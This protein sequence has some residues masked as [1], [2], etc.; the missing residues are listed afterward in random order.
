MDRVLQAVRS[1][2]WLTRE[3]IR[4]VAV[5][6]LIA[7]AAGFL[8]LVV[9]A[10]GG[11]DR[12]GRPIGTDFS[13]VYAAGTYVLEGNPVAPF[14]SVQQFARER[15]IFGEATQ[16]Y[17][18]CYPPYFL[19]IAAALAWMPYGLALFL[20]QAITLG[21][22]LLMI[23]A[24]VSSLAPSPERGGSAR[25]TRGGGASDLA[26]ARTP[27]RQPEP[28]IGPAT[29]GRTR[30]AVGLPLSGGEKESVDHLWLLIALAFPA[31]LINVGHGN[32]GFLT[33]ALL[34]GGLVSL[35][36]RPLVAGI[37]FGLMAYKPQ[38]ALM[39]PIALAAGGYWRS[40]V[41]AAATAVLLTPVTTLVFG[42]QVWHAFFVG[43][44]F[45]RTVVLEQG[46]PGWPKIQSIFSWARMWGAPVPLAYAIQGTATLALAMASAW[47]WHGKAPYPLKAA[48][49]C[50]AAILATPYTLDYDMMVLAP[51]IAFLAADGMAR[52][53]GPW[54]KTALAAL[55]LVPLVART[56]PQATL[57]PLGVPAM[58]MMFVL[59]LR[60]AELALA[61]PMA[62]SAASIEQFHSE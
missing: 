5:A 4:M 7:S 26:Q 61:L 35:D 22:Y 56:V 1:G 23:K 14:D 24:I 18:W 47:L 46:G 45:T 34:G 51:A 32:N 52:G 54:E 8:Y 41:A 44:E 20:W 15:A 2:E 39:I 29:S 33:A 12:Q 37:L 31:V 10:T 50:L 21:L 28:A 25:E 17:G 62:F 19:F 16:F 30:W 48:G 58:L 55:W 53:F 38:F 40:F 59:I 13:N 27:T 57:I 9:T 42:V 36:R 49:L 11:V 43:A 6:V 60:R 3:R